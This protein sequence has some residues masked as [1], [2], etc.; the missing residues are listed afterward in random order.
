MGK[1]R[2]GFLSKKEVVWHVQGKIRQKGRVVKRVGDRGEK[3]HKSNDETGVQKG[4]RNEKTIKN[5]CVSK[6]G[7]TQTKNPFSGNSTGS[8]PPQTAKTQIIKY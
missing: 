8:D 7:G 4:S 1:A 6:G 5:N 3:L 2:T